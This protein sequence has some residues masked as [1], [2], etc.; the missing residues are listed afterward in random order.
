MQIPPTTDSEFTF[1]VDVPDRE[2]EL[3]ITCRLADLPSH[4]FSTLGKVAGL[5]TGQ[6]PMIIEIRRMT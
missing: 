3:Y 6:A 5:T 1:R 2:A 4:F